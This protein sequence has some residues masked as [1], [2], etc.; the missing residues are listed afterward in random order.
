MAMIPGWLNIDETRVVPALQQAGEQLDSTD[1][2]AVLDFSS[3]SRIDSNTLRAM[4]QFVGLADGKQ[5]R[6]VLSGVNVGVY[7]V[8]KLSK[9]ASRFSFHS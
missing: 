1:G 9:L 2:E 8:L 7:K 6:V 3:V 5:V 4:E